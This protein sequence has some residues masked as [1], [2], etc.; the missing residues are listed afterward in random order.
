MSTDVHRLQFFFAGYGGQRSYVLKTG[1]QRV[2]P[3]SSGLKTCIFRREERVL[4]I[5]P[6]NSLLVANDILYLLDQ[7]PVDGVADVLEVAADVV[8]VGGGEEGGGHAGIAHGELHGQLLDRIAF[9]GTMLSSAMA[10][11]HQRLGGRMPGRYTAH[12]E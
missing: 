8:G 5:R 10:G 9:G 12:G 7:L 11:L 6:R 4:A 3:R 2:R 1:L